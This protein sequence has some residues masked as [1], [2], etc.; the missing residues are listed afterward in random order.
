MKRSIVLAGAVSLILLLTGILSVGISA[1][2]KEPTRQEV[3]EY[4]KLL[5]AKITFNRAQGN[6]AK[7]KELKAEKQRTLKRWKAIQQGQP[8]KTKPAPTTT[9][10][11]VTSPLPSTQQAVRARLQSL[12]SQIASAKSQGNAAR[13]KS[14]RAEKQRVLNH[15]KAVQKKRAPSS[16]PAVKAATQLPSTQQA[17][18]ARL[19]SL[20]SQIASAKSQGNTARVRHLRAEKQRVLKHWKAVQRRQSQ[21]QRTAKPKT[22][23]A[24]QLTE[25]EG[26]IGTWLNNGHTAFRVIN[27]EKKD[28]DPRG[29]KP[30]AGT[31]FY[32]VTAEIKNKDPFTAVYGGDYHRVMVIDA[33]RVYYM[34]NVAKN[35]ANWADND[36]IR[37]LMPAETFQTAY[38]FTVPEE[39][40]PDKLVFDVSSAD[41]YPVIRVLLR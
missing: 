41:K 25:L 35:P 5:D 18:R 37:E 17:V 19:Q 30:P 32:V 24:A 33:N 38:V 1:Q 28:T 40:V 7:V 39:A 16:A 13:A 9:P 22:A 4:I 20:D 36:D 26:P 29:Q 3:A 12:D 27:T 10:K 34:E 11:T 23:A 14:L 2:T 15:W 6:T 31:V 21:Q 8:A